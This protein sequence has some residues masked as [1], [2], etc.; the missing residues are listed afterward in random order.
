MRARIPKIFIDFILKLSAGGYILLI[1]SLIAISLSTIISEN[2]YPLFWDTTVFSI[3]LKDIANEGLMT[4][5]FLLIGLE[6]R[7]EIQHGEL[8]HK[9]SIS[10]PLFGALGGMIVPALIYTIVNLYSSNVSGFGIPTATDIA[11]SLMVVKLIGKWMPKNLV[12]L[13][14]AIAIFDDIG[15]I[16]LITLFYGVKINW[17]FI[18]ISLVLLFIIRK[19][20]INSTVKL[21]IVAILG[22]T[23]WIFIEC[24]GIHPSIAGVLCAFALPNDTNEFNFLQKIESWLIVPVSLIILPL[25]IL[26]NL[27]VDLNTLNLGL[28]SN[29][30]CIGIVLG[31]CVGKPLGISLGVLV[32]SRFA[33][34]L[35][36]AYSIREIIG[37][38]FLAGI[39]FTMSIFISNLAFNDPNLFIFSRIGILSGSVLS[40]ALGFLYFRCKLHVIKK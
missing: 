11:L 38:G 40:S 31:L 24:S 27:S 6:V 19:L 13:L 28:M 4:F 35:T 17:G 16:I 1:A 25:F 20:A 10:I 32:Y 29:P 39:G 9:G 26:I 36:K 37:V 14:T 22:F 2:Q 12:L 34:A 30:I 21:M 15:A 18:L 23:L 3:S 33:K 5:F 8:S 7:R